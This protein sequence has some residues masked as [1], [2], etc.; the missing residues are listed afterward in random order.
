MA[1]GELDYIGEAREDRSDD[2]SAE[3]VGFSVETAK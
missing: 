2:L 1:S 3:A